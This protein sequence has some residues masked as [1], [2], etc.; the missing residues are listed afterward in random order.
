MKDITI[1]DSDDDLT[2]EEAGYDTV[3]LCSAILAVIGLLLVLA[4]TYYPM[5]M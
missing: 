4:D 3:Y 1:E 5:Y 2:W